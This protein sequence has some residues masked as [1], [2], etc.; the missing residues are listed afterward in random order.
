[1]TVLCDFL[2]CSSGVR[3]ERSPPQTLM[4]FSEMKHVCPRKTAP[5]QLCL[6]FHRIRNVPIA[7]QETTVK[8][9]PR[10]QPSKPTSNLVHPD[11]GCPPQSAMAKPRAELTTPS[12]PGEGFTA[13]LGRGPSRSVDGD[14][15]SLG[16]ASSGA[17]PLLPNPPY[18]TGV[19]QWGRDLW[20]GQMGSSGVWQEGAR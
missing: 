19:L 15:E 3:E 17:N 18:C 7:V 6:W 5:V 16:G 8:T 4:D 20:L 13:G 1:M 11:W 9:A 10:F 12:G 2:Y 14:P